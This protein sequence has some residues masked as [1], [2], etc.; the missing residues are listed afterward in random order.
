MTTKPAP[1]AMDAAEYAARI[2]SAAA[3]QAQTLR[4]HSEEIDAARRRL[5]ELEAAAKNAGDHA[6]TAKAEAVELLRA[7]VNS[8][9]AEPFPIV[10]DRYGN[11]HGAAT[12]AHGR[13]SV[14]KSTPGDSSKPKPQKVHAWA[15]VGGTTVDLFES[16]RGTS[17]PAKI[18]EQRDEARQALAR[19]LLT[20]TGAAYF[21]ERGIV[22]P[23]STD[24]GELLTISPE[25]RPDHYLYRDNAPA[26]YVVRYAAEFAGAIVWE[27]HI[28]EAATIDPENRVSRYPDA[29]GDGDS[30][31]AWEAYAVRHLPEVRAGILAKFR[32]S[33]PDL[34]R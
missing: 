1:A 27:G 25:V 32:R 12:F 16:E 24:P 3:H 2:A 15:F 31:E 11:D 34:D 29:P 7:I 4:L 6:K 13:V 14:Q 26:G 19:F 9:E 22:P 21:E 23:D 18:D 10:T 17:D 5:Y 8:D 20:K 33:A 30:R 28:W